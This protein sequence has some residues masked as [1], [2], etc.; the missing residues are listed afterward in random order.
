ML[1]FNKNR[2]HNSKVQKALSIQVYN[3]KIRSLQVALPLVIILQ[4]EI[5]RYP[6]DYYRMT[7]SSIIVTERRVGVNN[8]LYILF[9]SYT[10]YEKI[11]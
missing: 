10:I 9:F 1:F 4:A 3:L 8:I 7:R 11:D 6:L 5:R 2:T